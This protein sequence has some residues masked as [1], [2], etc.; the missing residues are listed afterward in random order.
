M[1]RTAG[2]LGVSWARGGV[3]AW[4]FCFVSGVGAFGQ[5]DR[6][7]IKVG[8]VMLDFSLYAEYGYNDNV[9]AVPE[10]AIHSEY[11]GVVGP[12]DD[13]YI[14][15]G[16]KMGFEWNLTDDHSLGFKVGA[17][18]LDYQDLD[19]LDSE[20][21]SLT[22]TPESR[23]EAL[24]LFG[25]VEVELYDEF[26]YTL[27]PSNAVLVNQDRT[28]IAYQVD[29]YARWTNLAGLEA[30]TVLNPFELTVAV[31][32]YNIYNSDTEF[33]FTRREEWTVNTLLYYP[34]GRGKGAGVAASWTDNNYIRDILVDSTG[35]Y[36]GLLMD[37]ELSPVT[38]FAAKV[39]RLNREYDASKTMGGDVVDSEGWMYSA[40]LLH[41]LGKNFNHKLSYSRTIGYGR[42]TNEQVS[43]ML[44]WD[45]VFQGI[46]GVDLKGGVQWITSEDSG[47]KP[48]AE[49]YDLLYAVLG[50]GIGLTD[51]LDLSVDF[52]HANKDSDNRDRSFEQNGASIR[53]DY[54][55]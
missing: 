35:F 6:Y 10:H 41:L 27:D 37:W 44:A 12:L 13:T 9:T 34:L 42:A 22:I 17:A 36:V 24:L 8:D 38:S 3:C 40:E 20:N 53:L 2:K 1:N 48:F 45:F 26:S 33:D 46:K 7:N 15:Y 52:H 23:V 55:L 54:D 21:N 16:A 32:N 29:K 51:R 5:S 28:A 49:D 43:D 47:P 31:S 11:P 14:S 4:M 18:W 39:G 25:P 50:I 30:M 19:Y